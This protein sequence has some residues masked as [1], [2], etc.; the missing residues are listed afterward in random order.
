MVTLF[1]KKVHYPS[2]CCTDNLIHPSLHL[3]VLSINFCALIGK[4]KT[5]FLS[6]SLQSA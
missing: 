3:C 6:L 2:M 5:W 4:N 1:I